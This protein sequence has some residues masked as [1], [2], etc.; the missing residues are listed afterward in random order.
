MYP[1]ALLD[2]FQHPRNQG[3]LPGATAKIEA[4][5]P[6]CGDILDLAVIVRDGR[7][8]AARFRARGCPPAVACSSLLTELLI[9]KTLDQLRGITA[10]QIDIALGG[11][12][13]ASRHAGQLAEDALDLLLDALRRQQIT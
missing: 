11:L 4:S 12:P 1:P 2:H 5:N 8:T 3:D 9:G 6:V 13:P 10:E 7:V